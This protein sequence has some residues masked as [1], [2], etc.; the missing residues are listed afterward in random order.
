MRKIGSLPDQRQAERF[1]DYLL[2]RGVTVVVDHE[3]SAEAGAGGAQYHLWIREEDQLETAAQELQAF[4][5]QP[6]APQY[7]VSGSAAKI[8][9]QRLQE[10][11]RRIRLQRKMPSGGGFGGGMPLHDRPVY[12]TI[13]VI[14]LSIAAS[15][16]TE[17][18]AVRVGAADTGGGA[19]SLGEQV[20][21]ALTFVN[22]V[23][24]V[25][26][27]DPLASIKQGEIWRLVTPM[28]LH[29]NMP[30]LAFNMMAMYFL[31]SVVERIHGIGF[32]V[33][34]TLLCQ[35]V[36]A[37]AQAVTPQQFGGTPLAIGASGAVVGLFGYLWIRPLL[38]PSYPV[39]IPPFFVA[40]TLGWLLMGVVGVLPDIANVAHASG[41]LMGMLLA[42][43][44]VHLQKT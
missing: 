18:G 37:L 4:K 8:R 41:L 3:A 2:T 13:A 43:V 33:A 35:V 39:R 42:P 12:F 23:D 44:T 30:H 32:M 29:G 31:G 25:A 20:W 38:Q 34:M 40:L 22:F 5:Q 28:F 11:K 21:R 19:G 26:T 1:C 6:D 27:E 16:V 7:Q 17:F 24:F 9:N 14:V 36:S 10:A 15:L